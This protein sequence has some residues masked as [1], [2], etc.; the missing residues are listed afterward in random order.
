MSV[1]VLYLS[2]L[3]A[4]DYWYM[5]PA[6]KLLPSYSEDPFSSQGER[7]SIFPRLALAHSNHCRSGVVLRRPLEADLCTSDL[8]PFCAA[9]LDLYLLWSWRLSPER[10]HWTL[11][12]P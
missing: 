3:E 7:L 9:C 8:V 10:P 4:E 11:C 12:S 5:I 1:F 6:N 2:L